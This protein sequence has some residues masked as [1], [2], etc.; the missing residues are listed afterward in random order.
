MR[1]DSIR[2]GIVSL[3]SNSF[4]SPAYDGLKN[5][6][7]TELLEVSLNPWKPNTEPFV[8]HRVLLEYIQDTAVK[9]GVT[10]RTL[11]NTKVEHMKKE[12]G[13]WRIRTSTWDHAKQTKTFQSWVSLSASVT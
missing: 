7:P 13:H 8:S 5:N 2:F 11:F 10:K 12:Q 9:T 6:V 1:V 3:C 4:D